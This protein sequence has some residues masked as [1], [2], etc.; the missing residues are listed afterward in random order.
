[1][2]EPII[3]GD[4]NVV[5]VRV[6]RVGDVSAVSVVIVSTGRGSALP[7]RDFR[8]FSEGNNFSALHAPCLEMLNLDYQYALHYFFIWLMKILNQQKDSL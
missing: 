5:R 3:K 7:G 2:N 6:V 8:P 1:M 4:V